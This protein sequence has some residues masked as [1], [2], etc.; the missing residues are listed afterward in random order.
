MSNYQVIKNGTSLT[1][2]DGDNVIAF[3]SEVGEIPEANSKQ[4]LEA[5]LEYYCN[6]NVQIS[7]SEEPGFRQVMTQLIKSVKYPA[8]FDKNKIPKYD[9]DNHV[10]DGGRI[11]YELR[12]MKTGYHIVYDEHGNSTIEKY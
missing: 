12:M 7:T 5:I 2:R 11:G 1:V 3:D 8:G 10:F 6:N 9:A 4:I